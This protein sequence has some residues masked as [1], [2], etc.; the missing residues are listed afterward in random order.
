MKYYNCL[1]CGKNN[2]A[3]R[4]KVN[5]YCNNTCQLEFEYRQRITNWL[6]NGKSWTSKE[7]PLWPRRYL[8]QVQNNKCTRCKCS[9]DQI[10]RPLTMEYN[11][12]DGKR[13]NNEFENGEMICVQCHSLTHTY[14]AKNRTKITEEQVKAER[15]HILQLFAQRRR[16]ALPDPTLH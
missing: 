11:H 2:I 10:G 12:I 6:D 14:K 9:K 13:F 3:T 16:E 7:V 4:Q 5:K 1:N 8:L 15:S